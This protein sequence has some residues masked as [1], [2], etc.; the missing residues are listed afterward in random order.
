MNPTLKA[1]SDQLQMIL[2]GDVYSTPKKHWLSGTI[3]T[4]LIDLLNTT[5]RNRYLEEWNQNVDI[6]FSEKN[7]NKLE[8]IYG[9]NYVR[10][11][12]NILGRMKR[13]SNRAISDNPQVDN[14]VDWL[15]NS[16]G[17]VMFLNRKSALLQLISNVNFLN[18]SDNNI[19]AAA[20]AFANQPQYWKDVIYL[21]NSDYLVQRRNGLKINVAESEIALAAKKG[22]FK[23]YF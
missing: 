14:V 21:M 11:L 23:G 18:W 10:A 2:K 13:G 8:A 12:K 3:T 22:G 4:D 20:A 17:T 9:S 15:N 1:F 7:M 16:V 19:I 5:K 6:I